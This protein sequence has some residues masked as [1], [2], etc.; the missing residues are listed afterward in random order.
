[1]RS[2]SSFS[3][4][5][6]DDLSSEYLNDRTQTNVVVQHLEENE[7]TT[8]PTVTE[9]PEEFTTFLYKEDVETY[10][11]FESFESKFPDPMDINKEVKPETPFRLIELE[12]NHDN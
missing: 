5:T 2:S 3:S 11:L 12:L 6:D 8:Y 10:V 4:N 9:V 1:M 7:D